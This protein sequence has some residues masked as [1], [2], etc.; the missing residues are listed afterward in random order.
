MRLPAPPSSETG[1]SPLALPAVADV[2]AAFHAHSLPRAAWTHEAHLTVCWE[3]VQRLGVDAALPELR[4]AIRSYNEST[5]TS[6]TDHSGY[7]ETLTRYF[8]G[9]VAAVNATNLPE[10]LADPRCR[11]D[12]PF[13]HWTRDLLF[14]IDARTGWTNPDLAPLPWP[15]FDNTPAT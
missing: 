5:G 7:H 8:V 13:T 2:V 1:N 11:R 14:T 3:A 15:V 9:A 4:G 10:L 6:N 12:A